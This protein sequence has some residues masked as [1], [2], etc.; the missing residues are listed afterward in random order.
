MDKIRK[1]T[2][3]VASAV[4]PPMEHQGI[5]LHDNHYR[6]VVAPSGPVEVAVPACAYTVPPH[7]PKGVFK[8][9][10]ILIRSLGFYYIVVTY[11]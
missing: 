1:A 4:L 6:A 10:V 11:V 7:R 9:A 8:S 2:E 3:F 5:R